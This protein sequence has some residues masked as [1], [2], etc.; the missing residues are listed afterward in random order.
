MFLVAKMAWC[1][2]SLSFTI[3]HPSL[4]S[5]LQRWHGVVFLCHLQFLTLLYVPC[6]KHGMVWYTFVIYNS[7]PFFMFLV[8][9]WHAVVYLC[10]LQFLT[11]YVPCCK[12]GMM[13]YTFVIT[14]PHPLCSLLQRWHD[15]VYLCHLQFLTLYVSC[16][17][18]GM[19]WY[20]FVIYN[21]SPFMFLVAKMSLCGIPL[22]F[23]IP[24][25]LCSLLQ[26]WHDEVYRCHLQVLT[27]FVPC[28]KDRMMWY[29]V[30]I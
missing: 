10:H 26:R 27:L 12:D 19:L 25:P 3:P 17:K 2:I 15:V 6:C 24:N 5:L 11:L 22:S 21:S 20:T 29:T 18:D 13:W 16:C 4:C 14:T 7:S 8:A 28:C 30:L 1:S 23:T 9:R